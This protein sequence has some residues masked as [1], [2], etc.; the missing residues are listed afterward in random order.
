[1]LSEIRK[2]AK[3]AE[4]IPNRPEAALREQVAPLWDGYIRSKRI[5]LNFQ[6]RDERQLAIFY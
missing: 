6:P 5:N 2:A 4:N 3:K 1:M